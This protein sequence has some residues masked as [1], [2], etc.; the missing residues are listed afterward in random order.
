MNPEIPEPSLSMSDRVSQT[1]LSR[2][3]LV[4]GFVAVFWLVEIID[5]VVLSSRL[6]SN[7]IQPRSLD[8]LDGILWAPF[9][10]G[11]FAHLIAN[12]IPFM[13]LAGLSL[14]LG[15]RRFALASVIIIVAGG[16]AVWLFAIGSNE[17]HIGA[18]G[19]IFG[20]FGFLVSTAVFE[21]RLRS[22]ALALVALVFYGTSML[23]GLVP[24]PG[25]SWEGHLFGLLAGVLAGWFLTKRAAGQGASPDTVST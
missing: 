18:S 16:L 9:L 19:W 21:H 23:F 12:T 11:G 25:R 8:G 14:A 4:S 17:N 15:V 6:E 3:K 7:G 5:T 10:H 13:L 1:V 24:T 20:L 2:A 22:I